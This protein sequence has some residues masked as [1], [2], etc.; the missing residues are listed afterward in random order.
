MSEESL[1]AT[2]QLM[3]FGLVSFVV[4]AVG[5]A[6]ALRRRRSDAKRRHRRIDWLSLT[7]STFAAALIFDLGYGEGTYLFDSIVASFFHAVQMIGANKDIVEVDYS[8]VPKLAGYAHLLYGNI[9]FAATPVTTVALALS[10]LMRFLSS[11]RLGLKSRWCDCYLFSQLDERTLALAT[12]VYEHY[13][14]GERGKGETQHACIAFAD[15][16]DDVDEELVYAAYDLG[17]LC[18]AQ[19]L[20]NMWDVC[21]P[22]T[23]RVLMLADED[24]ARNIA[25]AKTLKDEVVASHHK[26]DREVRIIA[27]T[28]LR[29]SETLL[30]P[31][32]LSGEDNGVVVVTGVD[33]TRSLADDVVDHYPLFLLSD[34][35]SQHSVEGFGKDVRQRE[36]YERADRHVVIVGAGHVGMDFLSVSLWAS[37]I[38]G[39]HT[40]ISV[41]DAEADAV[42]GDKPRAQ[43]RFE[44]LAPEI[45]AHVG[46]DYPAP[47]SDDGNI[48]D[49]D[50]HLVDAETS[51][52]VDFLEKN[53]QTISYVFVSLGDDMR[54]VRAAMKTR[55]VLEREL[56]KRSA[57][58]DDYRAAHRPLVIAVVEDDEIA[59][60]AEEAKNEGQP[61]DLVCVGR[62]KVRLSFGAV[63]A[64]DTR[65]TEYKRRSNRA[66]G[67]HGKYRLFAFMRAMALGLH[68]I[69]TSPEDFVEL[70]REVDWTIT[71]ERK[72]RCVDAYNTYCGQ[73][74]GVTCALSSQGEP[75][76]EWLLRMEHARWN[77]YVRAEGFEAASLEVTSHIFATGQMD[78]EKHRSNLAGLHPCLVSFDELALLDEPVRELY[79]ELDPT[80]KARTPFQLLD[81]KYIG[82]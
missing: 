58:R 27:L 12:S 79:E 53:A 28:E 66:S 20:E 26:G 67:T 72:W 32:V 41:L 57:T 30:F 15:V 76:R 8:S 42:Q 13:H 39:V 47:E 25:L 62:N 17:A 65:K 55:Q 6:V 70:A 43:T 5:W 56:A 59:E 74:K 78:K 44:A 81:D 82:V 40:R 7:V 50:F 48:Y 69:E 4:F 3:L 19:P 73:D 75:S 54:N 80:A 49:L 77:A 64:Q 29:G 34:P 11:F 61:Y 38:D 46:T 36:L 24:E 16:D 18:F 23:M 31:E 37:R 63:F 71:P 2:P 35:K 33:L 51:S 22:R 52:Y 10:Y 9:L 45:M 1:Q 14:D 60:I 21:C 68:G